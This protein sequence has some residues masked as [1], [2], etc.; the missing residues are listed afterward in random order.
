MDFEEPWISRV[1]TE[2]YQGWV[3]EERGDCHLQAV[4]EA[5]LTRGAAGIQKMG[6]GYALRAGS[7][8][9][10]WAGAEAREGNG[11]AGKTPRSLA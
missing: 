9:E 2:H 4:R 5:A 7:A 1:F 8:E 11:G 3:V 6:A 10:L